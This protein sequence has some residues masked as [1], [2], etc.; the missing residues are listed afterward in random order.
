MSGVA[1]D[2]SGSTSANV[3]L[4]EIGTIGAGIGRGDV[5][6]SDDADGTCL[7]GTRFK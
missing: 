3:D 4:R 2:A 6:S 1:M 7:R 5:E